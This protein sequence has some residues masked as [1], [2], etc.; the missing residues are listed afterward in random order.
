MKAI[1]YRNYG[2]PDVLKCEEIEK[3]TPGDDEVLIR[4]RAASLNPLDY[5]LMKGGPYIVRIVL[6]LLGPKIKR[7]GR[8][9]AGQV[10]AVG[11]NVIQFKL[12]DEVFGTCRGA[13]AKYVCTSESALVMKPD[14]VT[15][16]Q[17]ASVP[18]AALTALQSL[19]DKGQIHHSV[20]GNINIHNM[21]GSLLEVTA[22]SGRITYDGDPGTAGEYFLTSHSGDL[23]ISIPASALV[24]IQAH[25][26]ERKVRAGDHECRQYSRS[27]PEEFAGEARNCKCLPLCVALV[28]GA[29]S[30]HPPL[31]SGALASIRGY[32]RYLLTREVMSCGLFGSKCSSR[33]R[34]IMAFGFLLRL[35]CFSLSNRK[36]TTLH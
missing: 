7:P 1:I 8:D 28:Q 13:L 27:R 23:E 29:D 2:S 35:S 10:E 14:N 34:R 33:C 20:S 24:E 21:S 5:H 32:W 9:V 12:G 3:P 36:S 6:G 26:F 4:V 30:C 15:F 17:A 22:G 18:V 16:E 19:R 11:R 25:S 31:A